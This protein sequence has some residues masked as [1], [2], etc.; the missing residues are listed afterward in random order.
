[1]I[2]NDFV[3]E[4]GTKISGLCLLFRTDELYNSSAPV[5][6]E[7]DELWV[8]TWSVILTLM[9][10][11]LII[12]MTMLFFSANLLN[13]VCPYPQGITDASGE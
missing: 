1:M 5:D 2:T 3:K 7:D 12:M 10:V 13:C 4:N 11:V 8:M 9:L 6:R